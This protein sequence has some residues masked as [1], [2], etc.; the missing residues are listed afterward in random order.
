MSEMYIYTTEQFLFAKVHKYY[1]TDNKS[2]EISSNIHYWRISYTS[3]N[4]E[5]ST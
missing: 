1:I 5:I 4:D 2:D 3:H